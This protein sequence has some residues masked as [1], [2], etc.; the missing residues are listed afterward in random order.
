MI[1]QIEKDIRALC[2]ELIAEDGRILARNLFKYVLED[3]C[4]FA[5][6]IMHNEYHEIAHYFLVS[7]LFLFIQTNRVKAHL[8]IKFTNMIC[9]LLSITANVNVLC[10]EVT[11]DNFTKIMPL[12]DAIYNILIEEQINEKQ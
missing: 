10:V 3:L 2:G 12:I 1:T 5:F 6:C 11:D 9:D 4:K 7:D 8:I